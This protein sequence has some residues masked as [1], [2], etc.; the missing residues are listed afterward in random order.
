MADLL[1]L[2]QQQPPAG[3]E[4][5]IWGIVIPAAVLFVSFLVAVGLYRHFSRPH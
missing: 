3:R 2:L 4:L 5:T 1:L